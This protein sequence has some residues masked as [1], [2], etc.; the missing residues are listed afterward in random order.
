MR[1]P[2]TITGR[3]FL[4]VPDGRQSFMVTSN[5]N[6]ANRQRIV[7]SSCSTHV[8]DANPHGYE[9][10]FMQKSQ[11]F[12]QFF[13]WPSLDINDSSS[14]VTLIDLLQASSLIHTCISTLLLLNIHDSKGEFLTST[15]A[16]IMLLSCGTP[17]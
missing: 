10:N 15:Q 8:F 9:I 4:Q 6:V 14:Q 2:L 1:L 11:I 3:L 13:P 5:H 16:V 12:K 17:R 7:L